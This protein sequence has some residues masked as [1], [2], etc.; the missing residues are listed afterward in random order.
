[1]VTQVLNDKAGV[2]PASGRLCN[3][4]RRLGLWGKYAGGFASAAIDVEEVG[5]RHPLET[6]HGLSSSKNVPVIM[7]SIIIFRL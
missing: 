7:M 1:M 2:K 3:F 4:H 6:C 5:R